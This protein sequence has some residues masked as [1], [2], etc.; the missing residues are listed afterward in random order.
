M[1]TLSHLNLYTQLLG[2]LYTTILS[3]QCSHWSHGCSFGSR[4]KRRMRES[5]REGNYVAWWD[6]MMKKHR[7][8]KPSPNERERGEWPNGRTNESGKKQVRLIEMSRSEWASFGLFYLP[9]NS[10]A[11]F[12]HSGIMG[13]RRE[14]AKRIEKSAAAVSSSQKRPICGQ[15][16]VS[17]GYTKEAFLACFRKVT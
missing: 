6:R 15:R 14:A 7:S 11:F 2:N 5:K 13:V 8:Q 16:S 10:S 12:P 4:K 9:L 1:A 3:D 17:K